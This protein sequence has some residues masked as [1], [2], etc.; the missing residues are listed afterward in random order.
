MKKQYIPEKNDIIWLDFEPT[1][2]KEIGK[3][4]PA[5]VLSSKDY[6][7]KTGLLICCPISTSIRGAATE[8][9]VDNLKVK[10]VV[11]A[12]LIQTLS[13]KDRGAEYITKARKGVFEEVILKII[14]LIGADVVL[15]EYMSEEE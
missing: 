14:P 12:S 5:L 3:L 11:A 1:K 13:W 8:V 4:R 7:Q 6:N 9:P 2:G 15:E 10:S